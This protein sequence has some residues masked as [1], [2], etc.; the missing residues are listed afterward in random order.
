M[1]MTRLCL[2]RL[3]F[4]RCLRLAA[5][6][7]GCS[8]VPAPASAQDW[9][10]WETELGVTVGIY[11]S[12]GESIDRGAVAGGL[13]ARQTLFRYLI[14][15]LEGAL[16]SAKYPNGC[17]GST[18]GCGHIDVLLGYATL[19]VAAT[20]PAGILRP[21]VGLSLGVMS[22]DDFGERTTSSW[23]VGSELALSARTRLL[24]EYRRRSDHAEASAFSASR[25]SS[26]WS[27]GL[28][29]RLF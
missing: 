18:L 12:P 20:L 5:V 9:S 26:Q 27:L 13:R 17:P 22:R 1:L 8:G 24:T 15:E 14:A 2:R 6:Y 7:A 21:F 11:S 23:T 19:G 3:D 28:T 4:K 16:V 29:V 25:S 10:S